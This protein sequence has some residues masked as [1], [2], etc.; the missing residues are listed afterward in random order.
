MRGIQILNKEE[1]NNKNKISPKL[2]VIIELRIKI[3]LNVSSRTAQANS[4]TLS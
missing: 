3:I 4:E 1:T 2:S